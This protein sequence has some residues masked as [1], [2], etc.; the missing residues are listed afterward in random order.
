MTIINYPL[1]YFQLNESAVLGILVDM[2]IQVVEKDLRSVKNVINRYLQR[3]YRKYNDF[4]YAGLE[5]PK[6]KL[7]EVP[8][9][10]TYKDRGGAYPLSQVVKVPMPVVYGE[11]SQGTYRCFLPLLDDSF[12]FYDIK[13]FKSLVIHFVRN[14]MNTKTPEEIYRYLSYTQPALDSIS[15]RVDTN[16]SASLNWEAFQFTRRYRILE[17]LAEKYPQS[18]AARKNQVTFPEAAWELEAKVDEVMDKLLSLRANVLLIG[19]RG[20]GKSA[21]LQQA[22]KRITARSKE[23]KLDFTFWRIMPQR[24][25]ASAKYLGEWQATVETLVEELLSTNGILWVETI[26][27][28]LQTGG[29]GSEDSVAAFLLSYLQQGKLQL[30]GEVTPQELESMRRLLPGFVE[31]FQLVKIEELPEKKIQNILQRFAE[32]S[33]RNLEVRVEEDALALLYRLLLRYYPYEAFPGKGVKFLGQCISE[34]K[35]QELHLVTKNDVIQNFIKQTGLPE[36]FLRDDM[37]LNQPELTEFF[38]S[39][40]IGQTEAV[41]KICGIVKIYKAGLNNPYK[42]ISTMLFAGPT[43]VG[44]T[45]SAKALA[46]YFFGK[47]QK[48]S[49]LVRIDMSEF[50]HPGQISRFIGGGR[51]VGQLVKDIRERPFSVLLLDEVEK[52]D[53]S[54]FD[55][56]MTVLDEGMMV[57]YYGRIT[58][59]RNSII[60]MTTNLGASNRKAVGFKNTTSD[61]DNYRSA[62]ERFFR[63]EF[64][65][66]IDNLVLFH[67]LVKED[68]ERITQKELNALKQ[69]EGFVKRQL[70]LQFSD[71][72]VQ[73]LS[74]IGFDERYGARPLQ[75]AIEQTL[76]NPLAHWLL[77]NPTVQQQRLNVDFDGQLRIKI[78]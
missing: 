47:G 33:E 11:S 73:Q 67:P 3:H 59:F 14:A 46:E 30:V 76:V 45:A 32:Y 40:I 68:I 22:I 41:E 52:A 48:Q 17:R 42:P 9:R 35:I 27:Q 10:P 20:V 19:N 31:N 13:Q 29:E 72:L 75:R 5:D 78:S 58:N 26:I 70:D 64:V 7:I 56:L 36:L 38:N 23:Q 12:H 15:L 43:G 65:N 51:E 44:K 34:A 60:I 55:A 8:V 39:R 4:Q 53:P 6:L 74:N 24:I 21:V 62:I 57:D 71:R 1:L 63:P 16:R 66:R 25:T 2:H 18:K 77:E 69:R 28:L 37:L 49:P 50:Q 61:E 54:I